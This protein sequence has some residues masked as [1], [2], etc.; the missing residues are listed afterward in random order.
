MQSKQNT[1]PA[2]CRPRPG[3]LRGGTYAYEQY[4]ICTASAT[5]GA[6]CDEV[7]LLG[8]RPSN[9]QKTL[10]GHSVVINYNTMHIR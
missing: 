9:A 1:S 5:G 8:N 3:P 2:N 10:L 4:S 7:Y 6:N